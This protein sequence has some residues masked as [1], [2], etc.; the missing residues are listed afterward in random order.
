M[1]PSSIAVVVPRRARRVFSRAHRVHARVRVASTRF[2]ASDRGDARARARIARR[3]VWTPNPNDAHLS[4]VESR[5]NAMRV[6]CRHRERDRANASKG[7]S[8]TPR[9]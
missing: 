2:S 9:R 6:R 7:V 8:S 1:H 4:R 3:R 5:S